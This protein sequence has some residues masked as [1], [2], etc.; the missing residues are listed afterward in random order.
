[1][2]PEVRLKWLNHLRRAKSLIDQKPFTYLRVYERLGELFTSDSDTDDWDDSCMYSLAEEANWSDDMILTF[3]FIYCDREADS[4]ARWLIKVGWSIEII[5]DAFESSYIDGTT[6]V[7][8]LL[9]MDKTL[10]EMIAIFIDRNWSDNR[11]AMALTAM[12]CGDVIEAISKNGCNDFRVVNI[13]IAM[14]I[15]LSEVD[16]KLNCF[17][18][19]DKAMSAIES[20]GF[21]KEAIRD[22]QGQNSATRLM[23]IGWD[24]VMVVKLFITNEFSS[25]PSLIYDLWKDCDSGDSNLKDIIGQLK[26]DYDDIE[27]YLKTG[28]SIPENVI[29]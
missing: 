4:L 6:L 3:E 2:N 22:M 20:A 23:K 10:T 24:P 17:W 26:I 8:T 11:I 28:G 15:D 13:I 18:E 5:F 9:E 12:D 14:S 19:E 7:Y 21:S 25:Q 27:E 16:A 29:D 1:M